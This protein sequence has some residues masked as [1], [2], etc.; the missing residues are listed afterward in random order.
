MLEVKASFLKEKQALSIEELELRQQIAEARGEEK[1]YQKFEEEQNIDGMNE[2]LE[3]VKVKLTSTP[4]SSGVQPNDQ[5][6]LE[7]L[8]VKFQ[9]S[10]IV[11]ISST[12]TPV[13]TP[14]LVSGASMNPTARLSFQECLHQR[15]R[16]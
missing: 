4:I 7:V 10:A 16:V 3:D 1:T 14:A 9:S 6:T 5:A 11:S 15:R 2:N 12:T 8:S 13:T